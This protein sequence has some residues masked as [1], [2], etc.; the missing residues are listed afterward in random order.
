MG[1]DVGICGREVLK[2]VVRGW[3]RFGGGGSR[4]VFGKGEGF[5][6]SFSE[7]KVRVEGIY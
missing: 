1:R 7:K 3:G 6:E 5:E 4:R 2:E